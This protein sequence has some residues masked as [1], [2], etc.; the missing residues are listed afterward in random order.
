M[1]TFPRLTTR[2]DEFRTPRLEPIP[3]L[4]ALYGGMPIP[5]YDPYY[6]ALNS[7]LRRSFDGC[8]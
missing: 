3:S 4:P 8:Q 1:P 7:V 2:P 5:E 6:G